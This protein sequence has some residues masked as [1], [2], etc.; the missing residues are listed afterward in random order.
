MATLSHPFH[1]PNLPGLLQ[2][3]SECGPPKALSPG[4]SNQMQVLVNGMLLKSPECRPKMSELLSH[5]CVQRNM[6]TQEIIGRRQERLTKF[7]GS[8]M[9]EMEKIRW[10]IER[11]LGIEC[12][13]EVYSAI[14]SGDML[15]CLAKTENLEI[16]RS[17]LIA[18]DLLHLWVLDDGI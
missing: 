12:M 16:R 10:R 1:G 2:A 3:I 14:R 17:A 5:P 18:R 13:K 4:Y 15:T 9:E 7:P 8:N 11:V 6:I